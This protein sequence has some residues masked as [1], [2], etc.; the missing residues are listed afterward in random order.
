MLNKSFNIFILSM[1]ALFLAGCF[2]KAVKKDGPPN[3]Y[4]DASKIPNAIPKQER[5]ANYGN[6]S[7]Y[8]VF[9]KRYHTMKSSRNYDETGTASWYGTKFHARRTSSGERYNMLAMTAA[10]KTLPLPTYVEVTN[11]HNHRKII[12]KVNDRGPFERNRIIDLSYVAAKKL[13]MSGR[14]TALVRVKAIDPHLYQRSF[15]LAKNQSPAHFASHHLSKKKP[16]L[17]YL[18]VATFRNKANAERLKRRL[19]S[20]LTTP[21]K[22]AHMPSKKHYQVQIGPIKDSATI[23]KIS[24]RLKHF[25][26]HVVI[27]HQI[28]VPAWDPMRKNG[29]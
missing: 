20:L 28:L 2:S 13:G 1:F 27:S 25:G 22:I 5:L 6:M 23:N 11:L 26:I 3:F 4:V 10:H 8:Y 7:I 18:Q 29:F 16:Q 24:N 12:V 15:W 19:I 9:G 21:V 14:G 17:L